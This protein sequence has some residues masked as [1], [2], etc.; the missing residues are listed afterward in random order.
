MKPKTEPETLTD[1]QIEELFNSEDESPFDSVASGLAFDFK[2]YGPEHARESLYPDGVPEN[3]RQGLLKEGLQPDYDRET[4][5]EAYDELTALALSGPASIALEIS[6]LKVSRYHQPPP[7]WVRDS[8]TWE[9]RERKRG[10]WEEKRKQRK[11]GY[12]IVSRE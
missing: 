4:L 11:N 7:P 8:R 6:A 2:K 3:F 5:L 10:E 12:P 1:Q 9:D